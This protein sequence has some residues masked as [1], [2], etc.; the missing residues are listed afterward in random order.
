MKLVIQTQQ[1]ENYGAHDWDGKGE[2]PQRWKF[3]GGDTYVVDNITPAQQAKIEA[4][5]IPNLAKLIET[6]NEAWREYVLSY[7]VV[8]DDARESEPWETPFR[9]IYTEGKWVAKRAIDNG[10]YGY[11]H[12]EIKTK[13]ESYVMLP[14]GE[15][16]S[17]IAEYEMKDGQF[18]K[19]EAELRKVLM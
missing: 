13:F 7:N 18:V 14:G 17:Y 11:M 16:T 6:W 12:R 5:G 15:R 4:E 10:E 19:G 3:K 8:A 9:L 1:C 2:C